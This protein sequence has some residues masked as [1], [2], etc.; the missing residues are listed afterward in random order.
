MKVYVVL[1]SYYDNDYEIEKIFATEEEAEKYT[2]F[3]RKRYS[4]YVFIVEDYEVEEK[5]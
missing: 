5:F 1:V 3:M 2:E 4:Q